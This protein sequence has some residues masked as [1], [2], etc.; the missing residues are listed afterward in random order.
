LFD[1]RLELQDN[2]KEIKSKIINSNGDQ[3]I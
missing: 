2:V 3:K 1:N